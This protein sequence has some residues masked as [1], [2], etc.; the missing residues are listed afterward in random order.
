MTDGV[1]D[2]DLTAGAQM[3]TYW[4]SLMAGYSS[5][6]RI[7]AGIYRDHYIVSI[8]NGS[9]LVD[10]LCVNLPNQTMWRFSNLNGGSFHAHTFATQE[11]LYMGQ[12]NAGRVVELSSLWFPSASVKFDGDG[13][14][15]TPVV[16]TGMFR[17]WDRLHRR[18][19]ESMGLQK[20]R[21]LYVDYDLRDS[22]SDFP[23]IGASY[24]TSPTGSY[25][26]AGT[27][28]WRTSDVSR[29]RR[30]LSATQ[31][32]AT[33]SQMLGLKLAVTGPYATAN[34]YAL[35]GVFE[36]TDIGALAPAATP[37]TPANLWALDS[38]ALDSTTELT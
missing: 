27:R 1:S 13:K 25:T 22:G 20:W 37:L 29:V 23:S 16:E 33:R 24:C 9:T 4:A 8:N 12:W 7:S 31:G 26:Q 2:V 35:E 30:A 21:W 11:K 28:I 15:P 38:G 3:K 14:A 6:W 17:G 18:W 32:G 10:C 36:P 19:I 5:S 34:L